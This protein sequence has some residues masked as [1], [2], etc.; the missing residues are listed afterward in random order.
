MET[1]DTRSR[2]EGTLA[3]GFA[4]VLWGMLT[5]YW[6]ALAEAGA[7]EIIAHRILWS[8]VFTAALASVRRL[9]GTIFRAVRSPA[10]V[11]RLAL[12]AALL[13]SN[14]LLY[15]WGINTDRILETSLGY[16]ITP[17]MNV[18][19]GVVILRERLRPAQVAALSLAAAGVLNQIVSQGQFP[20]IA[21]GLAVTFASYGLMRKTAALDSLPGLAAETAVL[22]V[23]AGIYVAVLAAGGGGALGH[24]GALTHVLLAGTGVITAVPLLLFAFGARR[25]RLTT[26]GILQ[27]LAPTGTFLLGYLAY[28]EPFGRT[29]AITFGLIWIAV[30]VYATDG[31]LFARREAAGRARAGVGEGK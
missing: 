2:A 29:R 5:V 27:Y 16:F 8:L 20:W 31:I 1:K 4:F 21:L 22:T 10:Q 11:G 17:L 14:W 30:V 24:A 7:V 3:T 26:V 13:S 6:K 18:A 12:S 9:W 19:L 25:I 15:V 23:P 28:H